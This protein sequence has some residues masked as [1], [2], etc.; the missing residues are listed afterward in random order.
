M[1]SFSIIPAI[2]IIDG[3][4][5]RLTKGD[6]KEKKIYH[7][8]PA[9]AAKAF[10]D[11]GFTRIHVVDLDGA[12]AGNIKNLEALQNIIQATDLQVDFSGGIKNEADVQ[13]VLDAGAV[14][15]AI[16]SMAVKNTEG[17]KQLV[18]Q[19]GK[20]KFWIGADVLEEKI[21]I[22]GWQEDAGKNIYEFIEEMQSL[23][24]NKLFC[25]DIAKDGMMQGPSV[26]LYKKIL[27]NFPEVSLTASGG[28][29]SI[30]DLQLLKKIGCT[31]AIVGKAIYEKR[32]SLK[33]LAEFNS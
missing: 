25:T 19:F 8:D 10:A 31:G 5:V 27:E 20:E 17:L 9:D 24:L 18:Q 13:N 15:I 16:G 32:I 6:Y 28:V 14:L 26:T 3:K 4:A 29:D 22:K 2:D 12:K 33:E 21:K 23:G 30:E 7:D 1:N 11:A